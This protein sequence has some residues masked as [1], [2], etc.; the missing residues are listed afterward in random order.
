MEAKNISLSH[1]FASLEYLHQVSKL[2]QV[3]HHLWPV[4]LLSGF[5][6]TCHGPA[7]EGLSKLITHLEPIPDNTH[8]LRDYLALYLVWVPRC[9]NTGEGDYECWWGQRRRTKS[10]WKVNGESK[11]TTFT[12][13]LAQSPVH[14]KHSLVRSAAFLL[15]FLTPVL[16]QCGAGVPRWRTPR[17]FHLRWGRSNVTFTTFQDQ[18]NS[19]IPPRKPTQL[20]V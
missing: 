12:K 5:S 11:V 6:C 7:N 4:Q 17:V 18:N 2:S 20:F 10:T 1:P 19:R 8:L 15:F 16:L 14:G 13:Y 3:S 9:F